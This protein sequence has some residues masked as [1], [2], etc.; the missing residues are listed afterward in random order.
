MTQPCDTDD[1]M[2]VWCYYDDV[3]IDEEGGH[4]TNRIYAEEIEGSNTESYGWKTD[5]TASVNLK[6]PWRHR[7]AFLGELLS[8]YTAHMDGQT[9]T[10]N[11]PWPHAWQTNLCVDKVTLSEGQN[12]LRNGTYPNAVEYEFAILNVSYV[13]RDRNPFTESISKMAEMQTL[14]GDCFYWTTEDRSKIIKLADGEQPGRCVHREEITHTYENQTSVQ[15]IF[16]TNINKVNSAEI[17]S[18]GKTYGVG[19]LLYTGYTSNVT[20]KAGAVAGV[21]NNIQITAK[22][23]WNEDGWNR[24][25][26]QRINNNMVGG[27]V[28]LAVG[29]ILADNEEIPDDLVVKIINLYEPADITAVFEYSPYAAPEVVE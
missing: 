27:Y 20:Y 23:L 13:P 10:E 28:Y 29:K 18:N 4:T 17:I 26:N 6:V 22:F 2:G 5:S 9:P 12:L 11:Q 3:S 7:Y 8:G 21:T 16:N 25:W 1:L 19:T 24:F 15:D 14:P